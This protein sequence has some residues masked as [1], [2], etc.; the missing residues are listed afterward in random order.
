MPLDELLQQWGPWGLFVSAFVSS[1]LAPGGSEALLLLLLHQGSHSPVWLLALATVGNTL[2]GATSVA[3]GRWLAHRFD[4][5]K[6]RHHA[7]AVAWLRR[8]GSPLLLLSWLPVVG[9]PLCVAAGWLRLP[10]P[11]ALL[12]IALG[13]GG[14]YA[15]LIWLG[16]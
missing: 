10:W 1:T 7:R 16:G 4:P 5:S 14:R 6:N 3:I 13:K 8:H 9:D 11:A 12:F 15:L 2:G